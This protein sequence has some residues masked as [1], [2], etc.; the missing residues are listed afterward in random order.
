MSTMNRRRFTLLG[1][2]SLASAALVACGN[3][4]GEEQ[5][6]NPTMIPDV[7]GAPPTLAP[8]ASPGAPEQEEDAGA[9][10]G[11]TGGGAGGV[12]TIE[13]QDPFNWSTNTLTA[14]PGDTIEMHNAGVLPHDFTI[15][16]LGGTVIP[17]TNGGETA[18]WT[19]PADA[20]PGD[21]IYYCSV[22]GHREGG[23]EG[24]L[25]LTEAGAA[26]AG[27]EEAT[28]AEGGAEA[29]AEEAP[30]GE[31]PAAAGGGEVTVE[32][33][34]TLRF[35]PA[36]L[37]VGVGGTITMTNAG[38]LPHD[39]FCDELGGE[40]IPLL[41]GGESASWEVPADAAPGT[42]TFYCSVPGHRDAGME[43]TLTIQ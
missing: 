25:T 14:A 22:P 13:A 24:T 12:V 40:L 4:V 7:P 43:G 6:I 11:E 31:A 3:E 29:P 30:A 17:L 8:M 35:E 16:E 42:Y 34:D 15:D 21:Y 33:L 5:A 27:G 37:T 26:P 41:N 20:A 1:V 32:S 28:P 10:G 38:V 36:E 39:L 23:M 9:G 19:I 18:S 2:G